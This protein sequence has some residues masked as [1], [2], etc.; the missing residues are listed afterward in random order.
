IRRFWRAV[1]GDRR[2]SG[3]GG[4]AGRRVTGDVLDLDALVGRDHDVVPGLGRQRAA[5]HAVG[6]RIIVVAVPDR[7]GE[8]AGIADEPGVAIGVGGAGLAGGRNAV[9]R[10]TARGAFADDVA[11][12]A[13]HVGSDRRR[14]GLKRLLAV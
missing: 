6:R 8:V 7:A 14:N 4:F 10:G 11:H 13:H 1:G 3:G 2:G 5:G 9:E 12:H